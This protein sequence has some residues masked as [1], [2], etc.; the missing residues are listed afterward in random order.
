MPGTFLGAV[1]GDLVGSPYMIE[2]TYNR[3]FDLGSGRRAYSGGRVRSFFPEAT[4]V[5]HGAA[6][7][8]RWLTAYRDA[9]TAENLQRCLKAQYGADGPSRPGSSSRAA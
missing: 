5:T 7:V 4:E 1:Y 9:P 8:V 3:Y 2:N 6:A